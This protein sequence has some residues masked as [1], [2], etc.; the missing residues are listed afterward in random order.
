[1]LNTK[2]LA[3]K[4]STCIVLSWLA[5]LLIQQI[6]LSFG[7]NALLLGLAVGGVH[8]VVCCVESLGFGLSLPLAGCTTGSRL[9]ATLSDDLTT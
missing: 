8:E 6:G 3:T 1:M 7:L 4:D 9:V 5:C 2:R